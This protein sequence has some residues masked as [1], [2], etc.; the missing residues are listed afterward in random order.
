[1]ICI[2][3]GGEWGTDETCPM[4]TNPDGT[5][6]Q[7]QE[8]HGYVPLSKFSSAR[9]DILHFLC[10]SD[11]AEA[12]TGNCMDWEQYSWRISNTAEDV[13]QENTEFSSILSEWLEMNPEVA[14]SPELRSELVGHF[15]VTTVS[16]GMVFVA[17]YP[18]EAEMLYD[19]MVIDAQFNDWDEQENGED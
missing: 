6:K 2:R 4:C 1:M 10:I 7:Y 17:S 14:D 12:S 16:S 3:H 18:T 13:Q 8:D 19:F 9:D 11:W 5:P 15:I